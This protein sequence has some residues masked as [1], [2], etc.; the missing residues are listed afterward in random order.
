MFE[1]LSYLLKITF[2]SQLNVEKWEGVQSDNLN[3]H[4]K[5]NFEYIMSLDFKKEIPV[6]KK[7]IEDL[8]SL[9]VE[10]QCTMCI[11]QVF[12]PGPLNI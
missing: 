3:Q 4:V 6:L 12:M 8:G 5:L 11:F 9:V 1:C 7:E 2:V 10:F